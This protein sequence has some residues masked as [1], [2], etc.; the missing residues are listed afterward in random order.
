MN[1]L[2]RSAI[3]ILGL[4]TAVTTFARV[5]DAKV[6]VSDTGLSEVDNRDHHRYY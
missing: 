2:I 5:E 3:I 4:V 6:Q 1:K